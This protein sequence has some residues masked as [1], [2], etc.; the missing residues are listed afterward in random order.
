MLAATNP[1]AYCTAPIRDTASSI[2]IVR[3]YQPDEARQV[4]A[5]VVI[6]QK[7]ARKQ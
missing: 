1:Y 5:L 3:E 4:A 2:S 6:L 7:G